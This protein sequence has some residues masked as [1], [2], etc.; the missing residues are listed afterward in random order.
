M[1]NDKPTVY[2]LKLWQVKHGVKLLPKEP[3]K[4]MLLNMVRL[5]YSVFM[6]N[7]NAQEAV[8]NDSSNKYREL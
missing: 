3:W 7:V 5:G 4:R 2:E 1:L 6:E 8:P